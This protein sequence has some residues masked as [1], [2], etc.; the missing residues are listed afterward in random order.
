MSESTIEN[1][2]AR[3]AAINAFWNK[4]DELRKST[5]KAHMRLDPLLMQW[6][7]LLGSI[8]V[9]EEAE[10]GTVEAELYSDFRAAVPIELQAAIQQSADIGQSWLAS[11][12][13]IDAA[14]NHRYFGLNSSQ[15][16]EFNGNV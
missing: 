6:Q 15:E 3:R 14:T 4:I 13:Q 2:L 16:N 8:E 7:E 10:P 5:A 11:V 1:Q 9:L 12:Y